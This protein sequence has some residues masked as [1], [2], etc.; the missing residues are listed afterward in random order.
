MTANK[1]LFDRL[2]RQILADMI[3]RNID[4]FKTHR[5]EIVSYFL[6]II[7]AA[8]MRFW[9]LGS[10][11]LHHDESL[12]AYFSWQLFMGNGY[13][14][15]PMMH[16]PLQFELNA[17]LFYIFGVTDFTARSMYAIFGVVL[18]LCPL[19]L[20]NKLGQIGSFSTSLLLAFSPALLYFSRFARNDIFMAVWTFALIAFLWRYLDSGKNKYLYG[21]AFVLALS[22][23][24]KEST[25]FTV[26]MIS[27]YLV[28]VL[29]YRTMRRLYSQHNFFGISIF[30][31]L[32]K[33]TKTLFFKLYESRSLSNISRETVFLI[34]MWT[35]SLP[36][37]SGFIALFQLEGSNFIL[38]AKTGSSIG[39]PS[40]GGLVI[41]AIVIA[42]A[43]VIAAI[44][45]LRWNWSVWLRCA[46]LFYVPWLL[47]HTTFFDNINGAGSG[48][49]QSLGYWI[50]QQGESRGNQPVYYYLLLT[51]LYEFLP[52]IIS[53]IA[54]IYYFKK[55]DP[56]AR[57]LIFWSL[58]T[59]LIYTMASEKMPW[60]LVQITLPLIVLSGKLLGD[61]LKN[62]RAVNLINLKNISIVSLTLVLIF[63]LWRLAFL[64]IDESSN[65]LS[66]LILLVLGL[67]LVLC[68]FLY[69]KTQVSYTHC[70]KLIGVTIGLIL[71]VLTI[72]SAVLATYKNGDIPVEMLVYTQTSPDVP[73]L[74]KHISDIALKTGEK[75]TVDVDSTSGFQWPWA[76]YL[77]D[78][79]LAGYPQY[80]DHLP[81]GTMEQQVLIIHSQNQLKIQELIEENYGE[82][83]RF[84]HRWWFPE[85]TYRNLSLQK[86]FTS[87][88][89]RTAWRRAMDYFIHRELSNKLSSED[90]Y[91]YFDDSD[92]RYFSPRE[93]E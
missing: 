40:G 5:I 27:L 49:W 16:G 80:G 84:R 1:M 7:I 41:A 35:V 14:H 6:L 3:Y 15:N 34:V 68:G 24:S 76:W 9:D 74:A 82:G 17:A 64:G 8:T 75:P 66:M 19:L 89:D 37:W 67:L 92:M 54:V 33:I 38:A 25:Y 56:F 59:F 85:Q 86:I 51:T 81:S 2:N 23:S 32:C 77:R 60:L 10:R 91:V 88:V 26:G 71:F 78:I 22:F 90:A 18:I 65:N 46:L 52:L 11:A 4:F 36:L 29:I 47:F 62:V 83:Q 55:R 93:L 28:S 57:F 50:V 42:I 43:F 13:I 48:L 12:H 39:S 70:A 79:A 21:S 69:V 20:R 63:L 58:A 31:A 87:L 30:E 53:I 45:G 72:R 44:I 61:C 73:V